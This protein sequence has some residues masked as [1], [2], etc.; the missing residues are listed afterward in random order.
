MSLTQITAPEAARIFHDP[1]TKKDLDVLA[2]QF[3]TAT[4]PDNPLSPAKFMNL[5]YAGEVS[6]DNEGRPFA[7]PTYDLTPDKVLSERRDGVRWNRIAASAKTTV[8]KVREVFDATGRDSLTSV[9]K[10][11]RKY[12]GHKAAVAAGKPELKHGW[13][14]DPDTGDVKDGSGRKA[15]KAPRDKPEPTPAA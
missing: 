14:V 2:R 12:D 11:G 3:S 9:P 5:V 7:R 10:R 8:S 4:D 6:P 1:E 15:K 13:T